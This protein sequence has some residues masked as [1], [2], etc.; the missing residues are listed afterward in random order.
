MKEYY[1]VNEGC[2]LCF[3]SKNITSVKNYS[4]ITEI[5]IMSKDFKPDDT[6]EYK[7]ISEEEFKK[8]YKSALKKIINK[9]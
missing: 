4:F 7:V 5:S 2:F 9:L 1:Q 8:A 6:K 3:E